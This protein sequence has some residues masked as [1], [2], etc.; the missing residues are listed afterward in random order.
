MIC[1][2]IKILVK[3]QLLACELTGSETQDDK[4]IVNIVNTWRSR[5]TR[6][7]QKTNQTIYFNR[8]TPEIADSFFI[9]LEGRLVTMQLKL[10]SKENQQGVLVYDSGVRYVSYLIPLG[11]WRVGIDAYGATVNNADDALVHYFDPVIY[12]SGEIIINEKSETDYLDV[13]FVTLG[14]SFNPNRGM[15]YGSALK[16]NFGKVG[17]RTLGGSVL[18]IGSSMKWRELSISF[19]DMETADQIKLWNEIQETGGKGV[20][21]DPYPNNKNSAFEQQH[22]FIANVD[23]SAF[24]YTGVNEHSLELNFVEI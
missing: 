14:Q 22:A 13:H 3:N 16:P 19:S 2:V 20:F 4:V 1:Q 21:V 5:I 11:T 15:D 23:T 10:Y 17:R 8:K 18:D 9:K 12:Q 7:K 6:F 24:K